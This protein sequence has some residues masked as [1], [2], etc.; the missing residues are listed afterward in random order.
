MFAK[1]T[2]F[3]TRPSRTSRQGMI[4]SGIAFGVAARARAS[5]RS[6]RRSSSALP[7]T[8]APTLRM[9]VSERSDSAADLHAQVARSQPLYR[10]RFQRL[11]GSR[12]FEIDHVQPRLVGYVQR[13]EHRL[14]IAVHGRGREVAAREANDGAVQQIERGD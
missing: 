6:M 12:R 9:R 13:V 14:R 3:T 4:R 8:H 11:A 10:V 5:A 7:I 2:P 1:F